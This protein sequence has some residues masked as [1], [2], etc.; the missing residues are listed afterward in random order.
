MLGQ[1]AFRIIVEIEV[2]RLASSRIKLGDGNSAHAQTGERQ[3]W[4]NA[5]GAFTMAAVFDR[6]LL[7]GGDQIEGPAIVEQ[8]DST[9]VVPA[10]QS[11]EVDAYGTL[12]ISTGTAL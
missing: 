9:T 12:V 7:L 5:I 6:K 2:P 10:G 1:C 11:A 4:D 3:L 8:F